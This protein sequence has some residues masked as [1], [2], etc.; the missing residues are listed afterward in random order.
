MFTP[1]S[2]H[3][4]HAVPLHRRG[5]VAQTRMDSTKKNNWCQQSWNDVEVA[6]G[7]LQSFWQMQIRIFPMKLP[8]L[9]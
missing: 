8:Q 4:P 3:Q 1:S 2:K 5:P 6:I 7:P 9:L